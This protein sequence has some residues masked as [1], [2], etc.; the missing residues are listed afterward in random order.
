MI[1]NKIGCSENIVQSSISESD[2]SKSFS[3]NKTKRE[4]IIREIRNTKNGQRLADIK[5]RDS[6]QKCKGPK[7]ELLMEEYREG[8]EA[9]RLRLHELRKSLR[10]YVAHPI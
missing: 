7:L 1:S 9:R 8:L 4:E 5:F 10:R 3:E 6:R 2:S